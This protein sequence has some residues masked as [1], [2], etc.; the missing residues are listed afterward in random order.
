MTTDARLD[1]MLMFEDN[2]NGE[3]APA[4][5]RAA[6]DMAAS[7]L[8]SLAMLGLKPDVILP[9]AEGGVALWFDIRKGGPQRD[10]VVAVRNSGLQ[11]VTLDDRDDPNAG[12]VFHFGAEIKPVD[13][14]RF[15]RGPHESPG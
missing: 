2:W 11:L 13:I 6:V 14:E 5:S 7:V 10:A 3:G 8:F 9:D 4:P 12:G 15:L 1:E